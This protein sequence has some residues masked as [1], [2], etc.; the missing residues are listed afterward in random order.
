VFL[1]QCSIFSER[2]GF[3]CI[4][5][6][7]HCPRRVSGLWLLP[8]WLGLHRRG[9]S[10]KIHVFKTWSPVATARSCFRRCSE[11]DPFVCRAPGDSFDVGSGFIGQLSS[12]LKPILDSPWPS[13]VCRGSKAEVPKLITQFPE[14]S[15]RFVQRCVRLKGVSQAP[16]TSGSRHKLCDSLCTNMASRKRVKT[17]LLPDQ[18][19][20]EFHRQILRRSLCFQGQTQG[21]NTGRRLVPV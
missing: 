4:A 14:P 19:R 8:H 17:A 21:F 20:E 9:C 15:R 2:S 10:G 11:S 3:G 13:I 12:M 18:T 5:N 7:L 1:L 16:P 6:Q